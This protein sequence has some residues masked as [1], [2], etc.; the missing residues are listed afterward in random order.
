MKMNGDRYLAHRIVH[1]GRE[2]KLSVLEIICE[3]GR[4]DV[5]VTPFDREIHST[6]FHNGTIAVCNRPCAAE[7]AGRPENH[8][9]PGNDEPVLIF[10]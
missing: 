2:Y 10:Y 4:Y 9:I 7:D 8:F 6:S 3:S 5:R 1:R